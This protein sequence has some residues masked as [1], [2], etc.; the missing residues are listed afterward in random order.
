M[1]VTVQKKELKAALKAVEPAMAQNS[2]AESA[3]GILW[4]IKGDRI[5]LATCNKEIQL[6]AVCKA[7]VTG[8]SDE[9][10][11]FVTYLLA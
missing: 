3:K 2:I 10:L 7:S 6:Q 1:K 9:T 11:S 4:F 5:V 8:N